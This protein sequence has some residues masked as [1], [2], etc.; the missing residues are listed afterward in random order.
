M[1]RTEQAAEHQ[2][3]QQRADG[4]AGDGGERHRRPEAAGPGGER[5]GEIGAEHVLHAMR[6]VHHVH[7]AEHQRQPRRDQEQQ[8]AELQ[9]VQRLDEQKAGG[10][11]PAVRR[12]RSAPYFSGQVF[13]NSSAQ[14][15]NTFSTI[16]V[17]YNPSARFAALTR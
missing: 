3:L 12:A 2:P 10:H 4:E 6:Q 5:D 17:S 14:S 1:R 16:S 13:A 15:E 8:H 7:D 9:P 11:R